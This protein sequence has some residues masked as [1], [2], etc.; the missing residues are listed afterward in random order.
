MDPF[1]QSRKYVN[2]KLT[3]ELCAITIKK[4]EK[5][6]KELTSQF[7]IAMRILRTFDTSTQKSQKIALNEL[8]LTKVYNV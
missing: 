1:I 8:L 3:E 7:K 4:N 5:F 2:L 6:E